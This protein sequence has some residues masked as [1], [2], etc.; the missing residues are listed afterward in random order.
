[1]I[2]LVSVMGRRMMFGVAIDAMAPMGAAMACIDVYVGNE[3]RLAAAIDT[4][5]L[6]VRVISV[7]GSRDGIIVRSAS[8]SGIAMRVRRTMRTIVR[9]L[10]DSRPAA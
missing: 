5:D 10:N 1:M 6:L 9:G 4:I 3:T 2:T 7:R 8:G